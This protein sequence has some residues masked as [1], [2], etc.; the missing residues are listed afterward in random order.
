LGYPGWGL[1]ILNYLT[2]TATL[3]IRVTD[4][5][6]HWICNFEVPASGSGS[7]SFNS[8]SN[9]KIK[10]EK[11]LLLHFL[12]VKNTNSFYDSFVKIFEKM[13][14]NFLLLEHCKN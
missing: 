14:S 6:P 7:M 2:S 9:Q 11:I 3:N 4:P 10:M 5:D 1:K 13:T 8:A 12:K